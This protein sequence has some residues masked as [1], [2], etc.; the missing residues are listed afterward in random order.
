MHVATLILAAIFAPLLA[1]W[2]ALALWVQAGGGALRRTLALLPFVAICLGLIVLALRGHSHTAA[3]C[4]AGVFLAIMLWWWCLRP[5]NERQW[6]DDVARISC[7]R[8][9]GDVAVIHNVRNFDWIN[10]SEYR[11]RWETRRYDLGRL[12]SF[13]M[14][15]S[16]WGGRAIAHVLFS[17]GF[18]DGQYLAF[19]VEIR[20]ERDE[21]YSPLGGFF[22]EFELS[23]IAADERD[24]VRVRT[25]IR[26]EDDYLY[27]IRLP[28]Q[29][30]RSL[31]CAYIEQMNRLLS[32]PR[33]YNT[34]T[35]NCTTLVYHMMRHI[36]GRL[37]FSYRLLLPG[38]LPAYVYKVGGLDARYSLAEL[39]Q[40]GRI[41]DRA[42]VS[43]R[44]EQFSHDIRI[45]IPPL[46]VP[47]PGAPAPAQPEV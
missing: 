36:I 47:Q 46:A 18:S 33:F 16:H 14:I 12:Q 9:D 28:V 32:T 43:D 41:T 10:R 15:T 4:F 42:R 40:W 21:S 6:A 13:D 3:E 26:R 35:V 27:H 7:G 39:S 23:V 22:K 34:I 45:G 11:Q 44:S 2:A 31:F 8:I 20:R 24:I 17:F 30:M 38:Y 37:P 1:L 25:N 5:S 29:N 19:S